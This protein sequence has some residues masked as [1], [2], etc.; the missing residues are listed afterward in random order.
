[1]RKHIERPFC[2]ALKKDPT[3]QQTQMDDEGRIFS[4]NFDRVQD[5]M[6]KFV[7]QEALPFNHFDN[8]R[9]TAMIRETLQ[10]RY[11]HVSRHALRRYCLKMWNKAKKDLNKYFKNLNTGVNLTSDVW[12]ASHGLP[13]SYLCVTAHWVDP[14]SWQMLKR[15]IAFELCPYPHTGEVLFQ[16]LDYVITNFKLENKIN[17]NGREPVRT[18]P[19]GGTGTGMYPNRV[20]RF[21]YLGYRNQVRFLPGTDQKPNKVEPRA[22][23]TG[24]GSA[25]KN[26]FD[27]LYIDLHF[28]FLTFIII[29]KVFILFGGFKCGV[30]LL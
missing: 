13:E 30:E 24:S 3:T 8:P 25:K 11:T 28:L 26:R 22:F 17:S 16:I 4:Y 14:Q 1:M 18:G 23:G 12:S 2:P 21:H 20:Y 9:L 27:H 29:F 5:R 6:T 19:Y 7:I 15:T 10:P